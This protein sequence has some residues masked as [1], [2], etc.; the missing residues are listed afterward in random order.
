MVPREHDVAGEIGHMTIDLS[1][2]LCSCGNIG[3]WQTLVSGPA[4]AKEAV[5]QL[6]NGKTSSL[7]NETIDGKAVYEAALAGDSLAIDVLTK[8][9]KY[10]GIGLTN[11]IH[12]FNPTKIT[13]T[14]GV[15]KAHKFL[16]PEIKQT[17][18]KRGLTDQAKT[19]EIDCSS[20]GQYGTA[21]GAATLVLA[22]IF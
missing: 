10:I 2:E 17:L 13:I 12:M 9:G 1:G 4:I 21:I 3:C 14:G 22:T 5:R 20:Q 6:S 19:T 15:A 11:L 18:W 7:T 8:T 16:L